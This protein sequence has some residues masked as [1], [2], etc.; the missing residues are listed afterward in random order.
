MK[1]IH[2]D[3]WEIEDCCYSVRDERGILKLRAYFMINVKGNP[4][5]CYTII[6]NSDNLNVAVGVAHTYINKRV[7]CSKMKQICILFNNL[8]KL[9]NIAK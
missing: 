7:G 5:D 8:K 9:E 1:K 4:W 3:G 2:P 6:V